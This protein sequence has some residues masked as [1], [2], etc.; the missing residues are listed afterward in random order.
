MADTQTGK[1]VLH[2]AQADGQSA[3]A[4]DNSPPRAGNDCVVT[5][6]DMALTVGVLGNDSDPD[7]DP[8]NVL[9]TTQPAGGEI[10]IQEQLDPAPAVPAPAAGVPDPLLA[11]ALA[12]A[13]QGHP[14]RPPLGKH[15]ANKSKGGCRARPR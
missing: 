12:E 10:T 9:S 5:A 14:D 11:G 6:E 4:G 1:N 8:L 15:C 3:A 7:G 13:R 2:L